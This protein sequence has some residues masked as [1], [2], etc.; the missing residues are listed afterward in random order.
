MVAELC[1]N[2]GK[3]RIA[4]AFLGNCGGGAV[5]GE[6][7]GVGG[8]RE[9]MV[10]EVAQGHAVSEG[11]RATTNGASEEGIADDTEWSR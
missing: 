7:D 6:K 3:K 4:F 1:L 8:E 11:I 2:C 5:A 9:N 10:S